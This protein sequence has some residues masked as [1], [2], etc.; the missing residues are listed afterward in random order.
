[1]RTSCSSSKRVVDDLGLAV[2]A[3]VGLPV[4]SW[5]LVGST[6]VTGE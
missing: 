2:V 5:V 6:V 1:M 4:G 3:V